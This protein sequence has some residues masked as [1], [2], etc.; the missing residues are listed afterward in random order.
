LAALCEALFPLEALETSLSELVLA[1]W[2]FIMPGARIIEIAKT[3]LNIFF[4]N[5]SFIFCPFKDEK[6]KILIIFVR[7]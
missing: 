3:I 6:I 2:A 4:R 5:I 1:L 7:Q